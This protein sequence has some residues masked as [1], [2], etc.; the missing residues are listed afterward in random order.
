MRYYFMKKDVSMPDYMDKQKWFRR[1]LKDA[2]RVIQKK[3]NPPKKRLSRANGHSKDIDPATKILTRSS[4]GLHR[5]QALGTATSPEKD[6]LNDLEQQE[7]E[8][9]TEYDDDDDAVVDGDAVN[10]E[11]DKELTEH[12]ENVE[13]S[14]CPSFD[15]S[16]MAH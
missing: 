16:S 5:Q 11:K 13:H 2:Y 10:I 15:G 7:D 6:G 9:D 1:D 4:N 12:V 8:I 14:V 3:K